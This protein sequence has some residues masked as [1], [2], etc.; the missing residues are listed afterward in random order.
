MARSCFRACMEV[1]WMLVKDSAVLERIQM[2]QLDEQATLNERLD[3]FLVEADR[4]VFE[5]VIREAEQ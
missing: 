4:K 3:A 5:T 1:I 2:M